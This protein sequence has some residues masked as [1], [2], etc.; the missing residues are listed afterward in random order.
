MK[1]IVIIG[2]GFAGLSA[3]SFLSC[4]GCKIELLEA[5]PKLGGRA[6]SFLDNDT[7]VA[8]D[9]GQHIIMGCYNETLNFIKLIG[10]EKNL[11]KQ[12]RLSLNFIKQ[13]F[14]I[15]PLRASGSL[16]PFNLLS[17]VANYSAITFYEKI[18]FIKFFAKIYLYEDKD[19]KK[20]TVFEWL[21]QEKQ[22]VNLI[23]SFWEILAVAAMNTDIKKASAFMFSKV[24]KRIFFRGNNASVII[25]PSVGLSETYC[26]DALKFIENKG[27]VISLSE[28][29]S[30]LTLQD[31][32]IKEI[33]TAKRIISDFDY[34]ISALP[35]YSLNK[36]VDTNNFLPGFDLDYSSILTAHL[37]LKENK[38]ERTFYGLIDSPVQWVFN[39]GSHLTIVI[40]NADKYIEKSKEEIIQLILCELN[41]YI[42]LDR[43]DIKT[44]RIIKE[45]RAAFVPSNDILEKRPSVHTHYKNFFLA[46]DWTNTGLPAT[47]ESAVKSGRLAAD[48]VQDL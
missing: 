36:I 24:L 32:A 4:S 9:N 41:K 33:V 16:Y 21:I 10:A 46:G 34:V 43:N 40:S 1:K 28:P 26:N 27:G 18:L 15:C 44:Y 25:L 12:S 14:E 38:I 30:K 29:V 47:I 2:G 23:K 8:I 6:Y 13:N 22:T 7:G 17:A 5:S 39:K 3:A 11:S 31:R 35:L 48:A 42:L 45:K 37:F 19:L 20:L